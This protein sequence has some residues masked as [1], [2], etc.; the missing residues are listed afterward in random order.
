MK[1]RN[2]PATQYV[3]HVRSKGYESEMACPSS[4]YG[5]LTIC[6]S[7]CFYRRRR[8][9][10]WLWL[11]RSAPSSAAGRGLRTSLPGPRLCLGWR[12]LVSVRSTLRLARGLL[13]TATV[14]AFVLGWPALLRASLL[15]RILA[16]VTATRPI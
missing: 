15:S 9:R 4:S 14:S 1:A 5:K 16:A 13:G 3:F 11:L 7:P 2:P 12:L 6:R 10:V 8:G